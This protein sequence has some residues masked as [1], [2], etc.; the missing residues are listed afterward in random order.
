MTVAVWLAVEL[1]SLIVRLVLLRLAMEWLIVEVKQMVLQQRS[2]SDL[3]VG[4][5][6]AEA[7]AVIPGA[8]FLMDQRKESL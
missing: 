5:V 2:L 1:G 3:Y 6:S 8:Y 4:E 7:E